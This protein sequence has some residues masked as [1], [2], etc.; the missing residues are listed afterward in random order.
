MLKKTT[1]NKANSARPSLLSL[2]TEVWP[3]PLLLLPA[4]TGPNQTDA[5]WMCF[6]ANARLKA[7]QELV[8]CAGVKKSQLLNHEKGGTKWTANFQ[9]LI[10]RPI[11]QS[12]NFYQ[13]PIILFPNSLYI[14]INIDTK[15]TPSHINAM[16]I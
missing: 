12:F 6:F 2:P 14:Q 10:L 15:I 4:N 7:S 16:Y 8:S 3:S 13:F 1:T 9:R 11:Y 5:N